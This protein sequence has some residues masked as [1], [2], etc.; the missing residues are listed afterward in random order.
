MVGAAVLYGCKRELIG[1]VTS[2]RLERRR[3][4]SASSSVI[5]TSAGLWVYEYVDTRAEGA[6]QEVEMAF[7][8]GP[9]DIEAAASCPGV[10]AMPF[11]DTLFQKF[12][13]NVTRYKRSGGKYY[14][15][16]DVV[17]EFSSEAVLFNEV[18]ISNKMFLATKDAFDFTR[19]GVCKRRRGSGTAMRTINSCDDGLRKFRKDS[20]ELCCIDDGVESR[21]DRYGRGGRESGRGG[22]S[23]VKDEARGG[24]NVSDRIRIVGI[25]IT[26]FQLQ[27]VA[28]LYSKEPVEIRGDKNVSVRSARGG[29]SK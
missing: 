28:Q 25:M 29:V 4:I 2:G 18:A 14:L 22:A 3:A 5:L 12:A 1:D 8:M 19:G 11:V 24:V 27:A 20:V 23:T 13:S 21:R 15:S 10:A 17:L 26:K 6:A 16:V 7:N 9:Y